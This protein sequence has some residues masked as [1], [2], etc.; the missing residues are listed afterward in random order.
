MLMDVCAEDILEDRRVRSLYGEFAEVDSALW[1]AE[2]VYERTLENSETVHYT[3]IWTD[4]IL[5]ISL[6]MP[7]TEA[8]IQTITEQLKTFKP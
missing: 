1:Q 3:V 7:P 5:E 2:Q 8:Q 6:P 4:R